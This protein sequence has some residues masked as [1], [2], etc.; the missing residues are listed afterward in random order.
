MEW[1]IFN[2]ENLN[3]YEKFIDSCPYTGIWHDP[4]WL[5]F[6]TR[7]GKAFCGNIFAIK[8]NDQIIL[9]GIILIYKTSFNFRYGY[10]QSGFLYKNINNSIYDFFIKNL[11]AYAK[12]NRLIFTQIDSIIPFDENFNDLIKN[13]TSH[14]LNISLPIPT[15][16]NIIDLD[17]PLDDL[18]KEMKP[19]G[20][21]NIKLAEKKGIIIKTGNSANI[22]EFYNLLKITGNR[23][24]FSLNSINYYKNMIKILP[25]TRLL[26]L[27]KDDI[28]IAGGIFL[29]YNKQGLY[30]YGASSNEYRN[31]MAPYLM[32]WEAIRI[33]K[34][35]NCKY[36]D[37][38]GIADPD[39]KLDRLSG[40]TDF[41]L[42]FGGRIVKFN[43]SYRITHNKIMQFSYDT[44][45]KILSRKTD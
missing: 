40:V 23:D 3:E 44:A 34:K 10:I 36:Y 2:N 18:L 33:A 38:M 43:T 24:G 17:K 19:K 9:S 14:K 41:K 31:L 26:L 42:K 30:Y 20:R 35:M 32:Q 11:N 21:Y 29:F 25:F 22:E 8:A 15:H 7:S 6:Q 37:F 27:Y 4:L 5:E 16:T 1:I 39:K 45:K 13:K 12:K 28:L